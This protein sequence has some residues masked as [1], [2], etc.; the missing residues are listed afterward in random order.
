VKDNAGKE[1]IPAGKT[2]SDEEMLGFNWYVEG[3]QG[4]LPN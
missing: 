2:M 3:V 4:K 1:R